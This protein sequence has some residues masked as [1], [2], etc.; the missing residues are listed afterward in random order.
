MIE[1]V[2]TGSDNHIARVLFVDDDPGVTDGIRRRLTQRRTE[3]EIHTAN[4]AVDALAAMA[5][6]P[7]D[8]VVSD[9]QMPG[10]TGTELLAQIAREY[11]GCARIILT[12]QASL[13]AAI[14][15]INEAR[16]F[17]FLTKPCHTDDLVECVTE[18]LHANAAQARESDGLRP[19]ERRAEVRSAIESLTLVFQPIVSISRCK[20]F[21]YEAL[22]RSESRTLGAPN[23]LL[24]AAEQEDLTDAVDECVFELAARAIDLAPPDL[25]LF[26]N[27]HP[28]S[29]AQPL[30]YEPDAPLARVASRVVL[31][32]TERSAL[33]D[34][35]DMPARVEALR[36]LGY[37]IAID[38]L[39]AG[40]SG[41]TY[42]VQLKPDFVK[43][44]RELV[45]QIEAS[46]PREKLTASMEKLCTELGIRTIAEGVETAA[47]RAVLTRIGCDLLQGYYFARPAKGFADIDWSTL[48]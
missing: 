8:A 16:I 23:L 27:V 18:A 9:E 24:A 35:P 32:L 2:V 11:P 1:G 6:Q 41:L 19:E 4:S 29:F 40:Y 43:F 22:M 48:D 47:E 46:P 21:A 3:W 15:A 44:D 14:R 17:R 10:M 33:D 37:R 36:G 42:L 34:I 39:G 5:Q 30:L 31:E 7:F 38:D 28:H 26:V 25:Q 45:H 20:P 12:G 13:D